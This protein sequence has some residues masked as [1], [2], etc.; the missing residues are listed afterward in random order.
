M[1]LLMTSGE[2]GAVQSRDWKPPVCYIKGFIENWTRIKQKQLDRGLICI[3]RTKRR[4]E[5][6]TEINASQ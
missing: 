5:K 1:S 2:D 3:S 4:E 6:S